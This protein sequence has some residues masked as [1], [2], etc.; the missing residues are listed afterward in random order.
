MDLHIVCCNF[1]NLTD[2]CKLKE[3]AVVQ[4]PNKTMF[5]LK[6][7]IKNKTRSVIKAYTNPNFI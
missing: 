6:I 7:N 2:N 1:L 3:N 5:L 4:K